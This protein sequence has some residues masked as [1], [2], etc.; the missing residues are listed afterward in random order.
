MASSFLAALTTVN[1]EVIAIHLAV[2]MFVLVAVTV[3]EADCLAVPG[4]AAGQAKH[5]S[6]AISSIVALLKVVSKAISAVCERLNTQFRGD[7]GCHRARS[8]DVGD[9]Q[10]LV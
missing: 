4:V 9:G 7:L 2:E 10:R 1:A 8:K 3:S 5:R 6:A